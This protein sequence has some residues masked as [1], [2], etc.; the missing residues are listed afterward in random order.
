MLFP[1]ARK[2]YVKYGMFN[3]LLKENLINQEHSTLI[4]GAN[5]KEKKELFQEIIDRLTKD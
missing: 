5:L 4:E 2:L 3:N 1:K